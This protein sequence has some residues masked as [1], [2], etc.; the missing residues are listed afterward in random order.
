[1]VPFTV[2]KL[3]FLVAQSCPT[4]S[5]PMDYSPPVSYVHGDSPGKNTE[6]GDHAFLQGILPKSVIEPKS[7]KLR[8]ASLMTEPSGKPS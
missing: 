7:P 8:V 5:N 6:V 4:L 2:Q 1:M 3:F